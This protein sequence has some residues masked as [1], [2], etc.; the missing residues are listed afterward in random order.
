MGFV[1][2]RYGARAAPPQ[3][4]ATGRCTPRPLKAYAQAEV[5]LTRVTH[6]EVLLRSW[7][8]RH[9]GFLHPAL[10]LV[11]P[12][13]CGARGVVIEQALSADEAEESP[14]IVVPERLYMTSTAARRQLGAGPAPARRSLL[15]WPLGGG[16]TGEPQALAQ[17]PAAMQLALLLAEERAKGQASFWHPYVSSLPAQLPCAWALPAP[18]LDQALA[19]LGPVAGPAWRAEVA[20]AR[21]AVEQRCARALA[22]WRHKLESEVDEGDVVW[23]L[24]QV[25]GARGLRARCT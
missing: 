21:S 23:A 20:K 14:L 11:D 3:M 18:D 4:Q 19:E 16:A 2:G 22:Q 15:P 1:P 25:R 12:A 17:L 8:E 6:E 24:G 13:P 9:G 7:I 5:T 10:R